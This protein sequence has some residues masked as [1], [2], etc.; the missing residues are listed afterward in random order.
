[1]KVT[2]LAF[3]PTFTEPK[4]FTD[5]NICAFSNAMLPNV[6]LVRPCRCKCQKPGNKDFFKEWGE[7]RWM[8]RTSHWLSVIRNQ[9]SLDILKYLHGPSTLKISSTLSMKQNIEKTL[10]HLSQGTTYNPPM[11]MCFEFYKQCPKN[12]LFHLLS[13]CRWKE[14][15][16]IPVVPDFDLDPP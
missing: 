9:T 5:P 7:I 13:M 6:K 2:K 14:G 16:Q 1:M 8:N 15:S 3:R 12:Q 10:A 4:I 11:I